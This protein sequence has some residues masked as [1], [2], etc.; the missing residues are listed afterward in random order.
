VSKKPTPT[1]INAMPYMATGRTVP[2]AEYQQPFRRCRRFSP[3]QSGADLIL[4]NARGKETDRRSPRDEESSENLVRSRLKTCG[5]DLPVKWTFDVYVCEGP[6]FARVKHNGDIYFLLFSF[7]ILA[8][9]N[10][11]ICRFS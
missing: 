8:E 9:I 1:R 6:L 7:R 4:S 10:L 5:R 11:K 3:C 2:G